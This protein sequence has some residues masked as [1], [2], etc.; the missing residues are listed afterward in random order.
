MPA[1]DDQA[2][3]ATLR[4]AVVDDH[5]IVREGLAMVLDGAEGIEVV[6]SAGN[7]TSALRLVRA[8]RPDVLVLDLH[9]QGASVLDALPRFAACSPRTAVVI[10][11][12]QEK[13]AYARA[14]LRAGV[15]GYVLKEAAGR[16]LVQAIRLAAEGHV[17]VNPELGAR[18]D[19][20]A[21]APPDGLAPRELD[22]LRLLALGHTNGEIAARLYLGVRTVESYRARIQQKTGRSSRAELVRYSLEHGLL[23]PAT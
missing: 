8:R 4:V 6:G 14:A 2:T 22:V 17:Y 11:T 21:S 7:V 5:T 12:M 19:G 20:E 15:Q 23:D 10:L 3:T 16:E 1:L 18:L 13:P 9:M